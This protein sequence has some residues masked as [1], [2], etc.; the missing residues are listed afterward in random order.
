LSSNILEED[1]SITITLP[2][3]QYT[4]L[5]QLAKYLYIQGV[6][7]SPVLEDF[8]NT[9][10]AF[11][12]NMASKNLGQKTRW[13]YPK[14]IPVPPRHQH[15]PQHNHPHIQHQQQEQ[16]DNVPEDGAYTV[17]EDEEDEPLD[18]DSMVNGTLR[19]QLDQEMDLLMRNLNKMSGA[20]QNVR[21]GYTQ[22]RNG[23]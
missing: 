21:Q 4:Y 5:A 20:G 16:L 15:Q 18:L 14:Q 1:K 11:Y 12:I 19:T 2:Q 7:P 10:L 3:S 17:E 9:A 6:A 23:Q 8:V 13:E 22:E